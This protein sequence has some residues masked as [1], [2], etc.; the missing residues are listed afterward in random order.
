MKAVVLAALLLATIAELPAQDFAAGKRV[1]DDGGTAL[2][3]S[4]QLSIDRQGNIYVL[5][6]DYRSNN[7]GDVR[8]SRSTDGGASF[9]PS[10]T[11]LSAAATV[12]GMQRGARIAVDSNGTLHILSQV[13]KK[14]GSGFDVLYQRSADGGGTFTAPISLTNST[15]KEHQDFPSIAVDGRNNI[16]VAWVDDRDVV[17]KTSSNTHIY[18]THSTDGGASFSTPIRADLMP[19]GVG[20]SCEC[21]NTDIA[22]SGDGYV[23]IAFRSNI[24][25]R[26][27]I[28]LARSVDGANSFQ[29]AIPVQSEPW[30]INACPMAGPT[31]TMDWEGTAHLAWRDMRASAKGKAYLYYATV[32]RQD[33][34]ASP[35]MAISDS[36]KGSS[37]PSVSVTPNGTILCAF[38]DNRNDLADLFITASHDGGNTFSANKQLL[39]SPA[40]TSQQLYP[41]GAVAPD[42]EYYVAWQETSKDAGDI[43]VSHATSIPPAVAPNAPLLNLPKGTVSPDQFSGFSWNTPSGLGRALHLHYQL[44]LESSAGWGQT[45]DIASSWWPS[46][47]PA[48]QYRWFVRAKTLTGLSASSDTL[49][50]TVAATSGVSNAAPLANT[51]AMQL[52]PNHCPAQSSTQ[53]R[54]ILPPNYSLAQQ[55]EIALFD[56]AGACVARLFDGQLQQHDLR[57][58]LPLLPAGVYRCQ[59]RSSSNRSSAAL[60]VE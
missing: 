55:V 3:A 31:V 22:A 29:T 41:V 2:Q 34:T 1:D 30:M 36:P 43:M 14:G 15:P 28:F 50:F 17:A 35:D 25:N 39:Q 47:L 23:T 51:G 24:N 32:R 57:L 4:P 13:S 10:R 49:S 11:V 16:Y 38:Q 53:L 18:A 7:E 56:M 44:N 48:G 27:D 26:R 20:G 6:T 12:S 45:D 9:G 46:T 54:I 8:L 5:W 40:N 19:D 37:Y 60:V 58:S 59:A 33:F 42:G 52:L 21:C